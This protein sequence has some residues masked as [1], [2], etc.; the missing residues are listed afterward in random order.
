[1]LNDK[2]KLNDDKTKFVIIGPLQQMAKVSQILS[3]CVGLVV[4]GNPRT[5]TGNRLFQ[6]L[7]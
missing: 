2:L 5:E 1:M 4:Q 6:N 3:L 7:R